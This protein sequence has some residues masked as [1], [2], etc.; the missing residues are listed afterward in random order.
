MLIIMD[1]TAYNNKM[2]EKLLAKPKRILSIARNMGANVN[3][4]ERIYNDLLNNSSVD[5]EWL[6]KIEDVVDLSVMG[7]IDALRMDFRKQGLGEFDVEK[8]FLKAMLELKHGTPDSIKRAQDS[9]KRAKTEAKNQE[10]IKKDALETVFEIEEMLKDTKDVGKGW[11]TK[12]EYRKI[13][14]SLKDILKASE[15]GNYELAFYLAST[16]KERAKKQRDL[17][18]TALRYASKAG[19]IVGKVKSENPASS[20]EDITKLNTL[21][22]MIKF[23]IEKESYQTALLLSKEVKHEAERLLPSDKTQI[24]GFV[25]PLCFDT[26]CPN[27]YCNLSISPSPLMEETCRTYCSCGTLYHICCIQKGENLTCVTCG[28]PLKG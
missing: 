22:S 3:R 17:K 24:S 11:S 25:C 28:K 6:T 1:L 19:H 12:N 27:T 13:E 18:Y 4:A 9:I 23:F 15:R 10:K 16:A 7:I 20:N 21:L 14:N 2:K 8:H 26:I 5:D